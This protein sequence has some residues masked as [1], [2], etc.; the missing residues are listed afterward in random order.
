MV[1][2]IVQTDFYQGMHKMHN[3][4]HHMIVRM[5]NA[6]GHGKLSMEF[7]G[8]EVMSDFTKM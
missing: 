7:F 6:M 2:F 3:H 1:F 5:H 8:G 4:M